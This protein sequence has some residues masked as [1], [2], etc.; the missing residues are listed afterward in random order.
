MLKISISNNNFGLNFRLTD[1]YGNI[2]KKK[3]IGKQNM[4]V[5][6]KQVHIFFFDANYIIK[7]MKLVILSPGA[8][9]GLGTIGTCLG[10]PPT[11]GPHLTKKN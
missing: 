1:Y 9:Y 8:D 4:L 3:E 6:N 10:P 7:S 11:G 5:P 2:S